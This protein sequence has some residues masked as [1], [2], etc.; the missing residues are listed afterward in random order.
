MERP[1]GVTLLASFFFVQSIINLLIVYSYYMFGASMFPIIYYSLDTVAGFILA[2]G[3]WKGF[4]WGK[5]GTII[6]SGVEILI[7]VLG[8][9]VSIDMQPA[10]PIQAVTKLIV[11]AIVIYFLTRPEI[12]EYFIK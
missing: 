10:D 1:F 12:S 11:Y 4:M 6:L 2:Y 3:M 9:V 8:I 7:G 5:I